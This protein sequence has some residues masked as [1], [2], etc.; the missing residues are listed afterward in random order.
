M[1]RKHWVPIL[2]LSL[3]IAAATVLRRCSDETAFVE[4]P[5][6]SEHPSPIAPAGTH[7]AAQR[8]ADVLRRDDSHGSH[9]SRTALRVVSAVDDEPVP[10]PR[11]VRSSDPD[12]QGFPT[13]PS[14]VGSQQGEIAFESLDATWLGE[15]ALVWA[16]GFLA[17]SITTPTAPRREGPT[18]VRLDPAKAIT[19][20]VEGPSGLPLPD[21]RVTLRPADELYRSY[22]EPP[23]SDRIGHPN[24][25]SPEWSQRTD[26]EGTAEFL[27]LPDR[28]MRVFVDLLGFAPKGEIGAGVRTFGPGAFV[29]VR[30]VEMFVFAACAPEGASIRAEDI[31]FHS[32]DNFRRT[33]YSHRSKERIHDWFHS[34]FKG[35]I[36]R[37][38]ALQ[39]RDEPLSVHCL[40]ILDDLR[41]A[42]AEGPMVPFSAF[43]SPLPLVP[44]EGILAGEV[45]ITVVDSAGVELPTPLSA[46]RSHQGTTKNGRRIESGQLT[47]LLEGTYSIHPS[48]RNSPWAAREFEPIELTIDEWTAKAV[49]R[50]TIVLP[51]GFRLVEV[52]PRPIGPSLGVFHLNLDGPVVELAEGG[53]VDGYSLPNRRADSPPI[54]FLFPCD[55]LRLRLTGKNFEQVRRTVEVE[56]GPGVQV[57]ELPLRLQPEVA[58]RLR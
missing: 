16:D 35:L 17:K 43:E 4:I 12:L 42:A 5:T 21:A 41:C 15:P 24:S 46:D 13:N 33:P 9:R 23:D 36:V 34:R 27:S 20:Q 1:S 56:A 32:H 58:A 29:R 48:E 39:D 38:A 28:R 7:D 40:A 57:I 51:D 3:A 2:I 30:M 11:M 10:S 49:Q 54:R 25:D 14:A 31:R 6:T 44:N 22:R 50:R 53:T 55:S 52:R 45:V 19:V 8:A 26:S 18:I 47:A 37:I